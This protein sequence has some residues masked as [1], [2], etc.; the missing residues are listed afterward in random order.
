MT[1]VEFC[2]WLQGFFELSKATEVTSEQMEVINNHLDMVTILGN[3]RYLDHSRSNP[4]PAHLSGQHDQI[5]C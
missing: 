4:T 1:P 5:K 2:Y 3:S